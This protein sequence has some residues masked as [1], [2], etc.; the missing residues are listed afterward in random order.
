[1]LSVCFV[2]KLATSQLLLG[3]TLEKK[4]KKEAHKVIRDPTK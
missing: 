1:M 3:E 2:E 4:A